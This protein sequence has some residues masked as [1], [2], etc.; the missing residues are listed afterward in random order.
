[1]PHLNKLSA[2]VSDA[3]LV[4]LVKFW[5]LTTLE[6]DAFY[7]ISS[8]PSKENVPCFLRAAYEQIAYPCPALAAP[9]HTGK[10]GRQMHTEWHFL[11]CK[12]GS[13]KTKLNSA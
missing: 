13:L 11:L 9:F 2:H 3:D 6:L 5:L 12:I 1:M 8:F 10:E 4:G 7:C